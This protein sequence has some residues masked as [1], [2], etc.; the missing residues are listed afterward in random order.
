MRKVNWEVKASQA[1]T[2]SRTDKASQ[3]HN[4]SFSDSITNHAYILA[5]EQW[6]Q[7]ER[8]DVI[9][10]ICA[11][12]SSFTWRVRRSSKPNVSSLP[13]RTYWK[14]RIVTVR[15]RQLVC[16]CSYWRAWGI[17]CR[18]VLRIFRLTSRTLHLADLDVR[19]WV[20]MY[21]ANPAT[22]RDL[23]WAPGGVFDRPVPEGPSV[24]V[25]PEMFLSKTCTNS[26]NDP[27]R[28]SCW[29]DGDPTS[30]T[31]ESMDASDPIGILSGTSNKRPSTFA[32]GVGN[33]NSS[34]PET[35][36]YSCV[37]EICD[38]LCALT[39]D[40]PEVGQSI[41]A[42]LQADWNKAMELLPDKHRPSIKDTETVV[43]PALRSDGSSDKRGGE[44]VSPPKPKPKRSNSTTDANN[45][46]NWD[47]VKHKRTKKN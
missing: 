2:R 6:N 45:K 11:L 32:R 8:Y 29:F 44:W 15:E 23:L 38:N 10:C 1:A 17:P 42:M 22:I 37:K 18:H 47:S 26:C 14:T 24:T 25:T 39:S 36:L 21:R 7:S 40:H 43:I 19:Y 33:G 5:N 28:E 3:D 31:C 27:E 41:H 20:E 12:D 30:V 16:S 35:H 46:A 13:V 9:R 4:D 34:K